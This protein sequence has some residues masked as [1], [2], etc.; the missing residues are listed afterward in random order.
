MPLAL[1]GESHAANER[2]IAHHATNVAYPKLALATLDLI[3]KFNSWLEEFESDY[4][5]ARPKAA[6][7]G[8]YHA[9]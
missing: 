8:K 6:A 9:G 1:N 2:E 3:H 4:N 5:C 7:V